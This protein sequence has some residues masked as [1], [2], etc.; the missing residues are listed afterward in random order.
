MKYVVT[1]NAGS[2]PLKVAVFEQRTWRRV[3]VIAIERI[4]LAKS[5]TTVRFDGTHPIST[6]GSI[7]T[8]AAA[9]RVVLG[10][11]ST[12][13]IDG[14]KVTAGLHR[15]VAG[16]RFR[17][18]V[19]ID[20]RV[21]A[22]LEKYRLRAPLHLPAALAVITAA[23]RNKAAV[24]IACFDAAYFADLP[25]AA[26]TLPID[27]RV[28]RRF[29]LLRLGYHGLSHAA[30][31]RAAADALERPLHKLSIITIHL[32]SG[33]SITAVRR[34]RP[35][36]TSMGMT[37]AEGLMMGTRSG[38][39]DP[40]VIFDLLRRGQSIDQVSTMLARQSG[41]LGVSGYSSDLRDIL[42]A[43]GYPVSGYRAPRAASRTQRQQ[44]RLA[45]EMFV[46]RIRKYLAAYAALLGR[47][48]AVA[49]TGAAGERNPQLRRLISTGLVLPGRPKILVAP[50]DEENEMLRQA[51]NLIR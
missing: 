34:G 33:C 11:L 10:L 35:V 1:W 47:V 32:G 7:A 22:E 26:T 19:R 8:P 17:R 12:R 48:D 25:A 2:S 36:E 45:L 44:S 49:F 27:R 41:L 42:V 21:I 9:V 24:Q 4:G 18:P 40:G 20:Q 5:I 16:G 38:D 14:S 50:T 37:P 43:S 13:G 3:A 31:A 51:R 15:V 30:A 29:N 39:I 46:W 23:R 6:S 28:A